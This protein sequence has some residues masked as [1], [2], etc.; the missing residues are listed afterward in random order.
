[1]PRRAARQMSHWRR[2]GESAP[3]LAGSGLFERL[4]RSDTKISRRDH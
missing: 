2:Q 3:T 1:M 4:T